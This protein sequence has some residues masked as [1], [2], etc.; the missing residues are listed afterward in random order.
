MPDG[1]KTIERTKVLLFLQFNLIHLTTH[2]KAPASPR[3]TKL[4]N[5]PVLYSNSLYTAICGV[6]YLDNSILKDSGL[7]DTRYMPS[8]RGQFGETTNDILSS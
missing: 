8:A 1:S 6:I 2:K 7:I 3:L 5:F 4:H